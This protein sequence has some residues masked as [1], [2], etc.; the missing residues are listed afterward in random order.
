MFI[1][2]CWGKDNRKMLQAHQPR[3]FS[4]QVPFLESVCFILSSSRA[5]GAT[6]LAA[7]SSSLPRRGVG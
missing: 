7:H 4:L 3:R 2:G 5:S 1:T 6:R